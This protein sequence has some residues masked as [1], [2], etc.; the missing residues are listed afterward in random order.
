MKKTGFTLIELMVVIAIIAILVAIA[1]G[2]FNKHKSQRAAMDAYGNYTITK[3][4]GT[5]DT[6]RSNGYDTMMDGS[7]VFYQL[8]QADQDDPNQDNLGLI[9]NPI[10]TFTKAEVK[11]IVENVESSQ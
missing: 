6:V 8:V 10:K 9:H 4:D 1:F 11:E 7:V 2:A 3:T 5:T